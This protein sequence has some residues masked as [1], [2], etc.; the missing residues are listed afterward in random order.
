MLLQNHVLAPIHAQVAVLNK[1]DGVIQ[2]ICHV[3]VYQVMIQKKT[4]P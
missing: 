2:V 4:V 3:V 1:V